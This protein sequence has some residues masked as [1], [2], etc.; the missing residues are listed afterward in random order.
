MSAWIIATHCKLYRTK[1]SV[2]S[3][4][5]YVVCVRVDGAGYLVGGHC[6]LQGKGANYRCTFYSR[7]VY[8]IHTLLHVLLFQLLCISWHSRGDTFILEACQVDCTNQ[9]QLCISWTGVVGGITF[10]AGK[11]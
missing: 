3:L 7:E 8:G 10:S 4:C 9:Q 1:A 2:Y 11:T 5:V 6:T